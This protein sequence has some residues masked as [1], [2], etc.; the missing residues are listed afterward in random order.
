MRGY[1]PVLRPLLAG[2]MGASVVLS[3]AGDFR[4]DAAFPIGFF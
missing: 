2:V 4:P 3:D 1:F